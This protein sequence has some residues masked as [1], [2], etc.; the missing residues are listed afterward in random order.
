MRILISA[1]LLA[2]VVGCEPPGKSG[3]PRAGGLKLYTLPLTKMPCE[4]MTKTPPPTPPP[5]EKKE[6]FKWWWP[7]GEK[8]Q[9]Q[10]Q[11]A[12]TGA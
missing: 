12:K 6:P 7:F 2:L 11:A 1:C 5:Q 9:S 4:G 10:P 3:D 8:D